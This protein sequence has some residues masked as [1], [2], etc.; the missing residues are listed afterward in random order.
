MGRHSAPEDSAPGD[1]PGYEPT[2]PRPDRAAVLAP[3]SRGDLQLLR[4]DPRLR[5]WCAG[6]AVLIFL[7]Y[8]TVIIVLG[9]SD[10][11]LIWV[12]IPTVLTGVVV[13]ALLDRTHRVQSGRGD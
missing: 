2:A 4:R 7:I 5:V 11:Y 1:A 9:R 13:G 12:W 6:A 3:G 10:V 8:T